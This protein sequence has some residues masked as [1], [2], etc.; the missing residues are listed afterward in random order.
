[1]SMSLRL[2]VQQE[3]AAYL[4]DQKVDSASVKHL[5]EELALIKGAPPTGVTRDEDDSRPR[6]AEKKKKGRKK[7]ESLLEA[8][9]KIHEPM[10]KP[11]KPVVKEEPRTEQKK[12]PEPERD[13]VE[14]AAEEKTRQKSLFDF[15]E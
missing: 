3:E 12:E 2:D 11:V 9:E 8:G 14:P 15:E 6:S 4:L 13:K 7:G 1:M 10:P 5:M